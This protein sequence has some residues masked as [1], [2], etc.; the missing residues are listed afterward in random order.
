MK[1]MIL[2]LLKQGVQEKTLEITIDRKTPETG[3][4]LENMAHQMGCGD[5]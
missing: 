4:T 1:I 2:I 3:E 5:T